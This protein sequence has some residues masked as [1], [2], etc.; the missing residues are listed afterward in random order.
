MG[1]PVI[2]YFY[3]QQPLGVGPMCNDDIWLS[4]IFSA[5]GAIAVCLRRLAGGQQY[6]LEV[7]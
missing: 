5:E 7:P 6:L 1:L 2:R 3:S 4:I